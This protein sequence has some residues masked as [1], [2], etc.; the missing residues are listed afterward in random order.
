VEYIIGLKPCCDVSFLSIFCFLKR[1]LLATHAWARVG[2]TVHPPS[3]SRRARAGS[4]RV[5][6]HTQNTYFRLGLLLSAPLTVYRPGSGSDSSKQQQQQQQ[7][8]PQQRHTTH[9]TCTV[10]SSSSSL[11][12][13]S[14]WRG[15][16]AV[17]VAHRTHNWLLANVALPHCRSIQR[18]P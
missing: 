4:S 8:Q 7:Q 16:A 2:S 10:S 15:F 17:Q 12:P 13:A 3:A 14:R 9:D 11:C 1:G 18:M 5:V 6:K